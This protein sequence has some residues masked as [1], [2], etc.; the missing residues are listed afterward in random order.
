MKSVLVVACCAGL[1]LGCGNP[2]GESEE[3]STETGVGVKADQA[4]NTDASGGSE[5]AFDLDVISEDASENDSLG[6]DVQS[7]ADA[8]DEEDGDV[9]ENTT[10]TFIDG[11]TPFSDAI[12][13]PRNTPD[14]TSEP[15]PLCASADDPFAEAYNVE[16]HLVSFPDGTPAPTYKA[17]STDT[18]FYLGGTEFWQKW[19]G[20]KNPTYSYYEGTVFGQRCMYA[21]ARRFEA[22]MAVAPQ[23]LETL[24]TQSNWGGSFFNWNDDF[25][26]SSW[27]NGSSAR[28]WAWRTTLVKWISQTNKDGTCY[29]PTLSMVESLATKCAARA[30]S[31]EGEIQGCTN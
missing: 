20:G 24:R 12:L 19:P 18:G 21:S 13:E 6:N 9:I 7:V 26:E 23:S 28:L 15:Q 29:L 2:E 14:N 31:S 8:F 11:D 22:I 10:D 17:A 25:S 1:I 4:C 16:Q 3:Q 27:G 30:D 5:Q